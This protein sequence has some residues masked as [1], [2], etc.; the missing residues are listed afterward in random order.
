MLPDYPREIY[1]EPDCPNCGE[2]GHEVGRMWCEDDVW[3]GDCCD[4]CGVELQAIEYVRRDKAAWRP[5]ETAPT[6]GTRVLVWVAG[7]D[8]LP[9]FQAIASHH[10]QAG[11]AV[12]EVRPT[13]HWMP[14]PAPPE[15]ADDDAE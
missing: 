7:C 12:D 11:W 2:P 10:P 5:I 4:D 9:A 14:L 6:D 13:T 3:S 15:Q 1:L 8:E